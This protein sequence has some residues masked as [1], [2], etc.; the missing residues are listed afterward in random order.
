[1]LQVH[2]EGLDTGGYEMVPD[3][4]WHEGKN[5]TTTLNFQDSQWNVHARFYDLKWKAFNVLVSD[6]PDSFY[7]L[8]VVD[9]VQVDA[10]EM[11]LADNEEFGWIWLF[12]RIPGFKE[13]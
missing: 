9:P 3:T 8:I 13:D 2:F 5:W 6:D 7:Y 11:E 12:Y 4:V 1:M 10:Y